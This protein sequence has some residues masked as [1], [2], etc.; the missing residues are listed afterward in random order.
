MTYNLKSAV[1]AVNR[2]ARAMNVNA[3][4]PYTEAVGE[5][6]SCFVEESKDEAD[7]VKREELAKKVWYRLVES[8][9]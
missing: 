7:A 2:A 3:S 1:S 4:M 9:L 5:I 6:L 8:K